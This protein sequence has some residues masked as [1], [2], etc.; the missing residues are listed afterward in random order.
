[1]KSALKSSKT[2]ALTETDWESQ[3]AYTRNDNDEGEADILQDFTLGIKIKRE[4]SAQ[5]PVIKKLGIV[6]YDNGKGLD[7]LNF[8]IERALRAFKRQWKTLDM[9]KIEQLIRYCLAREL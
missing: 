6:N 7:K 8:K 3:S 5:I 2:G 1:M 4:F 9:V